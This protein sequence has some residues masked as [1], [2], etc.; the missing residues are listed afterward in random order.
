MF[1]GITNLDKYQLAAA[2]LPIDN[3]VQIIAGPGTGKTLALVGRVAHILQ[4][5]VPAG[6]ILVL[7]FTNRAMRTFQARLHSLVGPDGYPVEVYTFHAFCQAILRYHGASYLDKSDVDWSQHWAIADAM[8][9][10]QLV[11]HM[12]RYNLDSHYI[13]GTVR[14]A[15]SSIE[16]EKRGL[17]VNPKKSLSALTQ[18]YN[19]EL[20][21]SN[22]V[23]YSDLLF[24]GKKLLDLAGEEFLPFKNILVDEF[25]D[26]SPVKW[27]L[28]K[29][30]KSQ[31]QAALTVVGDP[32]QSIYGFQGVD[33]Q[34]FTRMKEE[35]ECDVTALQINHRSSKEIVTASNAI[36]VEDF[37]ISGEFF[38]SKPVF[39]EFTVVKKEMEWVAAEIKKLMAQ[40][41]SLKM[42]D[43]AVL[44]R[45]NRGVQEA[46][47]W[48]DKYGLKAIS[49]N[50]ASALLH[51]PDVYPL[52]T[53]LKIIYNIH[54]VQSG[55]S[56]RS[57][58]VLLLS[59]LRS[60]PSGPVF[61]DAGKSA[62]SQQVW[63]YAQ[64]HQ[65]GVWESL[66]VF[67]ETGSRFKRPAYK[68]KVAEALEYIEWAAKELKDCTDHNDITKVLDKLI[69]LWELPS[70]EVSTDV[71][72]FYSFIRE[73]ANIPPPN[74]EKELSLLESVIEN[75]RLLNI[76]ENPENMIVTTVHNSK[77]LE[78]PVVFIVGASDRSFPV[79]LFG[80]EK[81]DIEEE[82][83]VLYVGMTR[84]MNKLYISC[85]TLGN[86]TWAYGNQG[87]LTGDPRSRFL[88]KRVLS[89]FNVNPPADAISA[90]P[91]S[92]TSP[93][94]G[95]L[96]EYQAV[97][98][99]LPRAFQLPA[100]AKAFNKVIH[101]AKK[102]AF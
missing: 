12:K 17:L 33:G 54:S 24:Y 31:S 70:A 8:D 9:Q 1:N 58:D 99:K 66:K 34:I 79:K 100:S 67:S 59:L 28:I 78:W 74:S 48:L 42:K 90:S 80:T 3:D 45:T 81:S 69:K 64:E 61:K 73:A 53:V 86:V 77:G 30:L 50:A 27:D 68:K 39:K 97:R 29:Q 56:H 63:N 76:S 72:R 98:N 84:A 25:Q 62:P 88:T 71:A 91:T 44:S 93:S 36:L 49:F 52:C 46:V 7:S 60:K 55:G 23:D 101:W 26:T 95:H 83:R 92:N 41:P 35:L 89:N 75:L 96:E 102:R 20:R 32:N 82:R 43:F 94:V 16:R 47:R 4:S 37:E 19:R 5:G 40:T 85:S 15:L 38:D 11:T 2:Q 18:A 14:A 57:L 51:S 21:R 22:L 13:S 87:R 65:C 10:E 6:A